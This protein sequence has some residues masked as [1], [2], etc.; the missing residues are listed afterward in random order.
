MSIPKLSKD[1]CKNLC[2]SE[3]R[4][5]YEWVRYRNPDGACYLF[6]LQKGYKYTC[7]GSKEKKETVRTVLFDVAWSRTGY[8]GTNFRS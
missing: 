1:D 6:K 4:S 2:P 8:N 7:I 5:N 3:E